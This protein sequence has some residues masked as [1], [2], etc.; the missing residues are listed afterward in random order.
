MTLRT[1][2]EEIKGV[3][4]TETKAKWFEKDDQS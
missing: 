2:M 3:E 1:K 4:G